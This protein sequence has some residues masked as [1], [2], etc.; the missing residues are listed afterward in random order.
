M[1]RETGKRKMGDAGRPSS[2]RSDSAPG[3]PLTLS[4]DNMGAIICVLQNRK[5]TERLQ[6]ENM[7]T[8]QPRL[9]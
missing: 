6:L 2:K 5:V 4:G 8:T 1:R 9:G 7:Y 3:S